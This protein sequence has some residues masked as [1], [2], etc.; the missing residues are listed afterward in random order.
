MAIRFSDELKPGFTGGLIDSQYIKGGLHEFDTW[1]DVD[2]MP[3]SVRK[4]GMLIYV[5]ADNSKNYTYQWDGTEWK[6]FN[7][8]NR[9]VAK[10]ADIDPTD[11][12][13]YHDGMFVYA[14]DT[15]QVFVIRGGEKTNITVDK[16]VQ[17]I[18]MLTQ[19]LID[20]MT[21]ENKLPEEYV[22]ISDGMELLEQ[23]PGGI[24]NN[25]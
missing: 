20:K 25:R 11:T 22:S 3:A 1:E 19:T 12:S 21:A 23:A 5:D 10:E 2:K 16:D 6:P 9:R 13:L 7:S 8:Y 18:P 4:K 24:Q 15:K 14:E 17:G